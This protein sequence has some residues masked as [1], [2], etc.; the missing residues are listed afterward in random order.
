[1]SPRIAI[2]EGVRTPYVRAGTVFSKLTAVDLGRLPVAELIARSGIEPGQIDSV[3]IGNVA[4]PPDAV[5]V[6]RVIGLFAGI[7]DSVPAFTVHRNCASGIQSVISAAQSIATGDA[8]IVIAGGV[9][10]M[11]NIPFFITPDL[12]DIIT[13]YQRGKSMGARISALSKI[14]PRHLVPR[15]G[16]MLGLTD[17][18]CRLDMGQTAEVLARELEISR[19]AQDELALLSH[20]RA[21]AAHE[22]GRFSD[23]IMPVFAPPRYD[24]AIEF[25]NG[26]RTEQ[27]MEALAKLRPVFQKKY[28]TVTAGNSSQITDGGAAVLLMSEKTAEKLGLEPLGF[29]VSHAFAGLEPKRMG[30]GPSY[31]TSIV[32]EKSGIDYSKIGLIEMNEAF[33][34]QVIANEMV[35][36]DDKLSERF[37]GRKAIGAIDRNVLNVNGGAIAMGHPVGSTGTRLIHTLLLEMQRRSVDLGLATLCVGGGQGASVLLERA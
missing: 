5:N 29:I 8:D 6:A 21:T 16:L 35:F 2:V 25:D 12:Q 28:G 19:Q 27:T 36:A 37:L 1:M 26:I 11:T 14:R 31:S 33:A 7:P 23:E 20:Q 4:Q 10:S 17:P 18:T 15:I 9:E 13:K 30:L 3:I 24:E 32:L 34:A 22:D